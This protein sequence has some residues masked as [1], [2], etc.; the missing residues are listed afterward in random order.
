MNRE[1]SAELVTPVLT[2]FTAAWP[3]ADVRPIVDA[4]RVATK[5]LEG[6]VRHSGDPRVTHAVAVG[7]IVADRGAPRPVVCAALLHEAA[8]PLHR[9][10]DEFG[11]R[12]ADILDGLSKLEAG[13]D[14]ASEDLDVLLV[15]LA[16]RLHNMRTVE[17]LAPIKQ[18]Q[19][20]T[21][22]LR[23]LA[24]LATHLGE[25]DI[26]H[27]LAVLASNVLQKAPPAVPR[28]PATRA[29]GLAA[30]LLPRARRARWL[31]EWAGEL[32]TLP[33][34]RARA[35]YVVQLALGMPRLAHTLRHPSST[36]NE[37]ASRSMKRTIGQI[38]V[39]GVY[40]ALMSN[41]TMNWAAALVALATLTLVAALLFAQTDEPARRLR[42]LINAW[43]GPRP[44]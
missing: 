22:T 41:A 32:A 18:Q 24:P 42:D 29:L 11:D 39:G 27:E 44:R 9:L 43:R 30:I 5:C 28:S 17:Y 34:R 16:D 37:P 38:I 20:A 15:K 2:A 36:Q 7:K 12:V 40:L 25:A 10:R 26:G 6:Q 23:F 31:D 1:S 4:F 19:K 33:T 21:D 13:D 8:Y 14:A 3:T 35:R